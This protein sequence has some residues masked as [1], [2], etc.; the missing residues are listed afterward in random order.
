MAVH[1]NVCDCFEHTTMSEIRQP[2]KCV[3]S[4]RVM[5]ACVILILLLSM[6][7]RLTIFIFTHVHC[8]LLLTAA[9]SFLAQPHWVSACL[10]L[11]Y[12]PKAVNKL[13][14]KLTYTLHYVIQSL[15]RP[16]KKPKFA[17]PRIRNGTCWRRIRNKTRRLHKQHVYRTIRV[18][19]WLHQFEYR[20]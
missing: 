10:I 11:L 8:M 5:Q 18:L 1:I 19:C 6:T 7:T 16:L 14:I 4:P 13:T 20:Q 17:H 9:C 12:A 3:Q 2:S 15:V